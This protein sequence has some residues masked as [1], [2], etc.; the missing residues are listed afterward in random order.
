MGIAGKVLPL[1]ECCGY[2]RFN[3]YR[4]LYL[5]PAGAHEQQ[6]CFAP[7][8]YGLGKIYPLRCGVPVLFQ[9]P[10]TAVLGFCGQQIR[11]LETVYPYIQ[12]VFPRNVES[13]QN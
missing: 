3:Y 6:R 7:I 8:H 5:E 10:V 4:L 2:Y 13:I 1:V 11:Q 9:F 12:K